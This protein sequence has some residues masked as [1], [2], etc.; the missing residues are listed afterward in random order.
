LADLRVDLQ[1]L[2]VQSLVLAKLLDLSLGLTYGG[3]IGQRSRDGLALAFPGKTE[4][5]A[6]TRSFGLMAAAIGLAS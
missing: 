1:K 4:V 3:G 2:L 6:V 5:G